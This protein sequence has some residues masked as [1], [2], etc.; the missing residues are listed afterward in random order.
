MATLSPPLKQ[1]RATVPRWGTIGC[2]V[3]LFVTF[4]FCNNTEWTTKLSLALFASQIHTTP[5]AQ[6]ALGD[7]TKSEPARNAGYLQATHRAQKRRDRLQSGQPVTRGLKMV[8]HAKTADRCSGSGGSVSVG[9]L[10]ERAVNSCQKHTYVFG[11]YRQTPGRPP[12]A[13]DQM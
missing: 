13:T 3:L 4:V 11:Q 10:L 6:H 7:P 12:R 2:T 9:R 8:N 1:V 5:N